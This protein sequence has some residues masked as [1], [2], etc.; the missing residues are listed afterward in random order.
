MALCGMT[1]GDDKG[2]DGRGPLGQLLVFPGAESPRSPI[3]IDTV[4]PT[5]LE[6]A[7]EV[8]D[9]YRGIATQNRELLDD[10]DEKVEGLQRTLQQK[11]RR[12]ILY[13]GLAFVAGCLSS[14]ALHQYI[15]KE[16]VA[17]APQT[18]AAQASYK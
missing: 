16:S 15:Q 6:D 4:I 8:I 10:K 13:V 7:L 3:D 11:S 17:E 5:T 18:E 9:T 1:K 12:T 14:Y 2:D